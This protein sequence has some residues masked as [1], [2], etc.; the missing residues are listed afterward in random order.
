VKNPITLVDTVVMKFKEKSTG[1]L[2]SIAPG[3]LFDWRVQGK[4]IRE[5]RT[6]FYIG[7]ALSSGKNFDLRTYDKAEQNKLDVQVKAGANFFLRLLLS[8]DYMFDQ[9]VLKYDL[10]ELKVTALF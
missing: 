3:I 10:A 9:K 2:N 1:Y 6:Q 4:W 5:C 8:I 7:A